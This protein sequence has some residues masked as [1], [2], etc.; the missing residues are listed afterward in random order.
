MHQ[1]FRITTRIFGDSCLSPPKSNVI[2]HKHA[3]D[4]IIEEQH[5]L[6]LVVTKT[7]QSVLLSVLKADLPR[8]TCELGQREV[9]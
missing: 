2:L 3:D 6:L 9:T 4:F 5:I 8:Q 7:T 1:I